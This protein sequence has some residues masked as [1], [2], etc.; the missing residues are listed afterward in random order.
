MAGRREYKRDE[1]GTQWSLR[2]VESIV[3]SP[4]WLNLGRD[5]ISLIFSP[6]AWFPNTC[7][8]VFVI[9]AIWG[10]KFK[11]P[12]SHTHKKSMT[13]LCTL[14]LGGKDRHIPRDC[15]LARHAGKSQFWFNDWRCLQIINK[16]KIWRQFSKH[17]HTQALYPHMHV[18]EPHIHIKQHNVCKSM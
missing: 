11:S 13:Y 9:N 16:G 15:W 2:L 7:L 3:K 17:V 14:A 8:W 1:M 10:P 6:S 4:L 18:H 12:E 5:K